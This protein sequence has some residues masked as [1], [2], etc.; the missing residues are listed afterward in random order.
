MSEPSK[1]VR[2]IVFDFELLEC[3]F[4]RERMVLSLAARKTLANGKGCRVLETN[5]KKRSMHTSACIMDTFL[6]Q[7]NLLSLT[8]KQAA[9]AK[10]EMV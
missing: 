3:V 10:D 8:T 6:Y 5:V 1:V 9:S 7:N 2:V 4:E